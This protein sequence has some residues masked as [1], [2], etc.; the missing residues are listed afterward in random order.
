[1]RQ[2]IEESVKQDTRKLM[3]TE[4][5]LEAT[6]NEAGKQ[7]ATPML[8]TFADERAKYLLNH[9]E[10][11]D[12]PTEPV[13]VAASSS[14]FRAIIPVDQFSPLKSTIS[15]NEVMSSGVSANKASKGEA[16][17]WIEL[18][19]E[20]PMAVSLGGMYLTDDLGHARKWKFP[21]DATIAAGGYLLVWADGTKKHDE[22]LH[23]NFKLSKEGETLA[24]VSEGGVI[25]ELSFPAL[26]E[27]Q[28]YGSAGGE[29]KVLKPSPG[30]P[31]GG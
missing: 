20:G 19:N 18:I 29:L 5:F 30:Q 16:A 25:A 6:A 2:L 24:L 7:V 1:M 4:A 10:I 31:N 27:G 23:T 26:S 28:S 12:L 14:P 8:R 21:K 9:D 13:V 15:I 17:D 3:S 22:S 11:K